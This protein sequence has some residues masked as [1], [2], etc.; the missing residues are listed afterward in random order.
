M[1]QREEKCGALCDARVGVGAAL[2]GIRRIRGVRDQE[3]LVAVLLAELA[4]CNSDRRVGDRS[5]GKKSV[6]SSGA[7]LSA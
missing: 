1:A 7:L 6:T 2:S 4:A 5:Q 3:E